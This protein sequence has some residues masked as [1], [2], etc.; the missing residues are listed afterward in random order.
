M[1]KNQ[2]TKTND[3]EDRKLKQCANQ[4]VII[5]IIYIYILRH[6]L[7]FYVDISLSVDG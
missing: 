7:A 1:S 2:S 6:C 5:K 3:D 4:I